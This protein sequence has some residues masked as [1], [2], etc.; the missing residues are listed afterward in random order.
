M[1]RIVMK[2]PCCKLSIQ[3]RPRLDPVRNP[4]PSLGSSPILTHPVAGNKNAELMIFILVVVPYFSPI[5]Q[6][7]IL[8][9]QVGVDQ[10]LLKNF[11]GVDYIYNTFSIKKKI[12]V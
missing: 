7:Y 1:S 5:A 11:W 8:G 4:S 2:H 3:A 6:A 10:E 12:Y 9:I